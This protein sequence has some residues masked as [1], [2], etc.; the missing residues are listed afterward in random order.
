MIDILLLL[1]TYIVLLTACA[2]ALLTWLHL[3]Q[4]K[5]WRIDRL[6]EHIAREGWLGTVFSTSRIAIGG[7][8]VIAGL[9]IIELVSGKFP[10]HIGVK[11]IGAWV[12]SLPLALSLMSVAQFLLRK[13]PLPRWTMKARMLTATSVVIDAACIAAILS[14]RFSSANPHFSSGSDLVWVTLFALPALLYLQPAVGFLAWLITMPLDMFLKRRIMQQARAIRAAHPRL[15][16]IGITG[17][18]GKTTTKELVA[19]LLAD[20]KPLVPPDHVNTEMGVSLWLRRTLS[21]VPADSQTTMVV[22]MGAYRTGEIALLCSIVQPTIGAIT[23]IAEQHLA[24]FGSQEAICQAKGELFASLPASGRAFVNADSPMCAQLVERCA[25]PV[26]AVATDAKADVCGL[27]IEETT[28]GLR[29]SV[30][31]TLF[32]TRL[33]GTH[34]VTNILLAIAIARHVG[35]SD[36][37]IAKR[38]RAYDGMQRTFQVRQERGVTVL[39]DTYNASIAS[40]TAAIEWAKQQPAKRKILVTPGIIEL[41]EAEARLHKDVATQ[42]LTVFEKVYVLDRRFLRYF[43]TAGFGTRASI[44]SEGIERLVS[45]DLLVCAG[46]MTTKTIGRFLP[47]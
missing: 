11:L 17:S 32:T 30:G 25:C 40:L 16:V 46:R 12:V 38:L 4:V 20:R 45:G 35:M 44:P 27:D 39:D 21:G 14:I 33:R 19:Y 15:T 41:G 43:K 47:L 22:E 2:S 18:V 36:A 6:R 34:N 13:Q 31:G 3:W 29:F 7:A 37:D 42:A 26:T 10:Q 24:L 9:A 1:A 28:E 8:W 5:E 23:R